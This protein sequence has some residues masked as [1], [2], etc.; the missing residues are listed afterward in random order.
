M[1]LKTVLLQTLKS[2]KSHSKTHPHWNWNPER[3][4]SQIEGVYGSGLAVWWFWAGFCSKTDTRFFTTPVKQLQTESLQ[5]SS[6][7]HPKPMMRKTQGDQVLQ[8][9]LYSAPTHFLTHTLT[10]T[11]TQHTHTPHHTH[12]HLTPTTLSAHTHHTHTHSPHTHTHTHTHTLTHSL[13]HTITHT[14]TH[15]LTL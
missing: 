5:N 6:E 2:Q 1:N 8:Q 12:T 7:Q 15:S 4:L 9:R 10:H 13:T 3:G 11:H 14:H